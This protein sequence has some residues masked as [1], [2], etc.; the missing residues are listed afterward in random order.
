MPSTPQID[1]ENGV[2]VGGA[3]AVPNAVAYMDRE[4]KIL[5]QTVKESRATDEDTKKLKE[6]GTAIDHLRGQIE[7]IQYSEP[8]RAEE[9]HRYD[10]QL[11]EIKRNMTG[12]RY[13]MF[14]SKYL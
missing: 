13:D 10:Y 1:Q 7:S 2:L 9:M 14:K 12:L 5:E 8:H 3:D 6:L 4:Y 11:G